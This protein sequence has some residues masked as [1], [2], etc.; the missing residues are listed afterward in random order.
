MAVGLLSVAIATPAVADEQPRSVS[1]IDLGTLGSP[2]PRASATWINERGEIVGSAGTSSGSASHAFL[3]RG[4]VMTDLG[5][6]G[7]ASSQ[8]TKINNSGVVIGTSDNAA[9]V[10][11]GFR[12]NNGAMTDLGAFTPVVVNNRGKIV[13]ISPTASGGFHAAHWQNG[14]L[15]DLGTL[16]GNSIA[17]DINEL[18]QIVGWS[19]T[20]TGETHAI[21]WE[22]G[23]IVDLGI[24]E[25]SAIN[26][27]GWIVGTG[28][29]TPGPATWP[30]LWR[31]DSTVRLSSLP[32]RATAINNNDQITGVAGAGAFSW[33]GGVL[34]ELDP[35][36]IWIQPYAI[37]ER[38]QI[39][40]ELGHSA[41]DQLGFVW[42]DGIMTTLS[43]VDAARSIGRAIN[44]QGQAVG[45]SVTLY[46]VFRATLWDVGQT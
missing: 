25:A 41:G 31:Q 38:G 29:P 15:T 27:H 46:T 28:A 40:G 17:T 20:V 42:D 5:T 9:G 4:G 44:N 23:R 32:G 18:G 36:A 39:V 21:L 30:T 12:W 1:G 13:G 8:A 33:R 2:Y 7:G 24:G 14:V 22:R 26:D 6:L 43:P 10:W 19:E 34:T 16:G 11:H 45:V 3:W 37:N 35:S